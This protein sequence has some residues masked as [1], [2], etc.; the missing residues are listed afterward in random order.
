MIG[1]QLVKEYDVN[2]ANELLDVP[3][4]SDPIMTE[5]NDIEALRAQL[6]ATRGREYWRSLEA[7]AET[8]EFKEFLHREFPQNASEWLDPVGRRGFLKLM[9]AS[10]ALAG[11]QRLHAAAGRGDRSVRASAGRAGSR[12]AALLRD[13]DADERRGHRAAGR[14]PRGAAD[15]DRRQPRSSDEPRRDR[16][17]RPGVDPRSLRSRIDRRPS[18][19]SAT[20][21][22]S[23]RSS[24]A[25]KDRAHGAGSQPGRGH[26]D[27]QRNDHL[28]DAGRA[29]RRVPRRASRRRSGS[30]GNRSAVTTRGR[31]AGSPSAST[32]TR[33]TP[34]TRPT[35]S[36]RSTPTSSARA[37]RA[38]RHARAFASRRRLEGDQAQ[39][40]RLYAVESD[41][42]N[43]GIE[44]RSSAAAE[45][46]ATIEAFARAVAARAGR[47]RRGRRG[48]S[49]G[50]DALD[51]RRSSRICRQHAVAAW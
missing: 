44:G 28:A 7:L 29:D 33:S 26:P 8:P 4:M 49:A 18:R 13:G 35:S 24:A 38:D 14:E 17:V 46:A 5:P 25:L 22:R 39:L 37:P 51:R 31:A 1:P 11:R 10:L 20:F 16:P 45:G 41:A 50:G 9:G 6:E 27:P 40:N 12:Q 34:S 32:S 36:S 21:G 15:E 47:R 48:R 23:A 30:S 43:T 3:S 42:T 19:T 2:P